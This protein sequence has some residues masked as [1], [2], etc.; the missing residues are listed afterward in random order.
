MI[1]ILRNGQKKNHR[2]NYVESESS[3]SSSSG[4]SSGAIYGQVIKPPLASG[5]GASP[6]LDPHSTSIIFFSSFLSS[7]P[8]SLSLF[9]VPLLSLSHACATSIVPLTRLPLHALNFIQGGLHAS[10]P[11]HPVPLVTCPQDPILTLPR[12]LPKLTK[13]NQSM[14]TYSRNQS[15]VSKEQDHQR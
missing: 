11:F 6:T 13:F 3:S 7:P 15:R 2:K 12:D 9:F 8:P 10:T 14:D 5:T 4:S 1:L